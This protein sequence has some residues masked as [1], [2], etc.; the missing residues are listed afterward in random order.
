MCP[1]SDPAVYINRY[2]SPLSEAGLSI[3]MLRLMVSRM[4]GAMGASSR[5]HSRTMSMRAMLAAGE[6]TGDFV[7]PLPS[8]LKHLSIQGFMCPPI[9]SAN[10][11]IAEHADDRT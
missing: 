4:V 7:R 3:L 9:Q 2:P 11:R 8:N 6:V 5:P 10:E 1:M